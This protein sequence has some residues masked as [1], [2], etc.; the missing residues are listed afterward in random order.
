[1]PNTI[2]EHSPILLEQTGSYT[3]FARDA[4]TEGINKNIICNLPSFY[5][6]LSLMGG[7]MHSVLFREKIRKNPLRTATLACV[8]PAYN[9]LRLHEKQASHPRW[10]KNGVCERADQG[11]ETLR[12]D[13]P[14][15]R[16]VSHSA[17]HSVYQERRRQDVQVLCCAAKEDTMFL[18]LVFLFFFF[19]LFASACWLHD[20]LDSKQTKSRR[21]ARIP[22]DHVC[23]FVQGKMFWDCHRR[24]PFPDAQKHQ[25]A[26]RTFARASLSHKRGNTS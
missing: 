24:F 19:V 8:E 20:I 13:F 16:F 1:M 11:R 5:Q 9:A 4:R 23:A 14:D 17:F 12:L 3:G 22:S 2:A 10:R 15:V 21:I 25:R 6:K 26:Q 18:F 7:N